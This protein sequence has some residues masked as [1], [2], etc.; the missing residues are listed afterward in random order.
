[1]T[2]TSEHNFAKSKAPI[3]ELLAQV[4]QIPEEEVERSK[5][6]IHEDA[7]PSPCDDCTNNPKNGG[8]GICG[9]ILGQQIIY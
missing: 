8:N 4:G 3:D 6:I 9:C 1:M 5:Y 2:G 7:F